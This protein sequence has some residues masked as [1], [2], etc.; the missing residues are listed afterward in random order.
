MKKGE[1][2]T[3]NMFRI[4]LVVLA[5]ALSVAQWLFGSFPLDFFAAP[6]N[7]L[8]G[9][10]WLVALWEGYCRR[11]TSKLVQYLLSAE[12]TY[13]ALVVAVVVAVAL[14]LQSEPATTSWPVVGG[15]L[16]V[17]SVLTLVL[18]R[19]WRNDSGVRWRFLAT[20]VGLWLAVT[21]ALLGAPD[22]EI[23]RLQVGVDGRFNTSYYAQGYNP[24]LSVF[25]N[26]D[27]TKVGDYPYLDAFVAAKWKRMRILLKYQHWN[28]NLFRRAN[29]EYFAIAR[30]PL[31]PGMFKIGISWT[32]Y[33]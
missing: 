25:Y 21:S 3:K 16:F 5:I 10:L 24:A 14:G 20:H 6:M 9:A 4:A 19:G 1:F 7:L 15:L 13:I 33:D 17:Q 23:L 11:A 8:L 32:F 28:C 31:N 12:A 30:Y 18:L 27:E 2:A 26:Q 29:N 22:K